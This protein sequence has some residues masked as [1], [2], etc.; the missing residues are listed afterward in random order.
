VS[1][2]R[3]ISA[4]RGVVVQGGR[5]NVRQA[6]QCFGRADHDLYRP[7]K[8]AAD[9]EPAGKIGERRVHFLHPGRK[10]NRREKGTHA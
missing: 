7:P 6:E 8:D 1:G 10:N 4:R 5:R 9:V 3:N 2:V